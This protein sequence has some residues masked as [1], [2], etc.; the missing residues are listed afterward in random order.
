MPGGSSPPGSSPGSLGLLEMPG[1]LLD[2]SSVG[3]GSGS[4]GLGGKLGSG[5]SVGVG[6]GS[7]VGEGSGVPSPPL[8]EGSALGPALGDTEGPTEGATEGP[9]EGATEGETEGET[10]G[11]AMGAEP[12]LQVEGALPGSYQPV[13]VSKQLEPASLPLLRQK[14][15]AYTLSLKTHGLPDQS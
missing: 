13:A 4:Q 5:S 14:A 15:A 1:S 2:G 8:G 3:V 7:S 10:V 12:P 6:W 11:P 9:T